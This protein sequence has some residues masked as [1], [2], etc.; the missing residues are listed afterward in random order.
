M[1]DGKN[2]KPD[3]TYVAVI[4]TILIS[5]VK[6][7][8]NLQFFPNLPSLGS[9]L[10]LTILLLPIVL[11]LLYKRPSLVE[12]FSF[13]ENED[14]FIAKTGSSEFVVGAVS[15]FPE[16]GTG[17]TG[18][19]EEDFYLKTRGLVNGLLKAGV[20]TTFVTHMLPS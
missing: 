11:L 1:A 19:G 13:R 9:T 15:I 2:I 3:P 12:K 14:Y 16:E 17:G 7:L 4:I 6:N 8:S 10:L 20:S 5:I 18:T